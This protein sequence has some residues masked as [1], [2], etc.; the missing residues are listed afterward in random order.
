ML[1]HGDTALYSAKARGR[2]CFKVISFPLA[3]AQE[4]ETPQEGRYAMRAE[5]VT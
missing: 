5:Q 4:T 3:R 1:K 2:K